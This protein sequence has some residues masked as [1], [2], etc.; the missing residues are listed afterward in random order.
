MKDTLPTLSG[1][2]SDKT[3]EA[4][5][6]DPLVCIASPKENFICSKKMT[7]KLT[8]TTLITPMDLNAESSFF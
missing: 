2:I 4:Q 6:K 7:V 8:Y 1:T 5:V 3:G